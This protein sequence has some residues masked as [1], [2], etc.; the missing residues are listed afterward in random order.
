ME[1]IELLRNRRSARKYKNRVIEPEK[2]EVLKEAL[3]RS[4]TSRNKHPWEFVFADDR[5]LLQR[6]ALS[7]PHGAMFL[8]HAALGIVVCADGEKSDVWTEDCSIASILVQMV[9]QSMGLGSC[10][11]QIRNRIFGEQTASEE[12]VRNLLRMP[13]NIRIESIIA[14]GYPAEEKKPISHDD[15]DYTKIRINSF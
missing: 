7:K 5:E 4:P 13:S 14:L 10:W 11:I 6:L 9:A 8:E 3:L 12:H 2:I 15:L 1:M